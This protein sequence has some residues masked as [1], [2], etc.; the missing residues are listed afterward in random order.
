MY[1]SVLAK[2][3]LEV[4]TEPLSPVEIRQRLEAKGIV[5]WEQ[6]LRDTIW[7]LIHTVDLLL[8]PDRK[9]ERVVQQYTDYGL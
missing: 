8:R 4:V 3:I 9:V 2:E 5:P 1:H 7:R 6:D